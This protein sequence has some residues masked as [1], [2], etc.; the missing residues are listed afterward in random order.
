MIN[1][2]R[3]C[4][5]SKTAGCRL[6]TA[7]PEVVITAT[8]SPLALASPSAVNPALRSSVRMCNRSRSIRSAS[9]ISYASGALRE[10]GATTISR[11]PR[12]INSSITVRAHW[13]A[14]GI[15]VRSG[16]GSA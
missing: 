12:E 16:H 1:G 8:G 13:L 5:A 11:T 14:S 4:E 2:S 10:P 9:K 6:A 15:S 7:V 3:L